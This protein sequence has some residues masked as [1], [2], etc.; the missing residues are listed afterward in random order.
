VML[1]IRRRLMSSAFLAST[2]D[3]ASAGS[4]RH[5]RWQEDSA[6]GTGF[7]GRRRT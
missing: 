2:T 1:L 4:L 5:R 6:A 7:R 3:K